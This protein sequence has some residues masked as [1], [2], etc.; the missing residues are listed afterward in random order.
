M[1]K[2]LVITHLLQASPRI[3]GL[4]KYLDEFGWEP[5]VITASCLHSDDLKFRIIET[6]QR[7]PFSLY[8][9]LMGFE[10]NNNIREEVEKKFGASFVHPILN[11]FLTKCGEIFNYPDSNKWWRSFAIRAAGEVLE[12]DNIN[13]VL[14]SSSPI[15]SHIIARELKER[16]KIPWIADLRDLWTQNH[17]YYYGNLRKII[18]KRLELK[19]LKTADALVTVSRPWAEKLGRFHHKEEA[20]YC[21]TN[22]FDPQELSTE[23]TNLTDKFT[24]TYTGNIYSGKQDPLKLFNALKELVSDG[25]IDSNF[26][27]IRFYGTYTA[28]LKKKIDESGLSDMVKQYERVSQQLS[29]KKQRESQ[30]LLLLNWEDPKE[31]GC[32]PL[33][34]FE[35]LAAMRPIIATGGHG[36]DVVKE[37]IDETK[38]GV[39][40][41]SVDEIKD[42]L[43]KLY[44]EYKTKHYLTYHGDTA[45][46]NKYNYREM[47]RKFTDI[48]NQVRHD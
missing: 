5:I 33:K 43:R 21:I 4:I 14:S 2:V 17:N 27:E 22:G 6:S 46:I 13:V 44:F 10:R 11:F 15:T 35:Y 12:N 16:H 31:K 45:K 1:K 9:G 29:F 37:L 18:D 34:I 25:I 32:Y 30:L 42:T 41:S 24:I 39:Y 48:F 40:A 23:K 20:T 28:S 47:A 19:T 36:N 38:A 3:S 7:G 26:V 8:E